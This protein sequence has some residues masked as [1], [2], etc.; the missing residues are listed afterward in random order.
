MNNIE[1]RPVSKVVTASALS[2]FLISQE[3]RS[4]SHITVPMS[5]CHYDRVVGVHT[6]VKSNS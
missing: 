4:N 2:V 1:H 3:S 6:F 5:I